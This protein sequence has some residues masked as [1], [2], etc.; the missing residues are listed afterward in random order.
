MSAM[1][2]Q[3]SGV[4]IVCW[5]VCSG[6]D[7][8][9]HQSSVSLTFVRKINRWPVDSPQK[10]SVKRKMF[11]F[12][13]NY[14]WYSISVTSIVNAISCYIGLR[15]NGTWPYHHINVWTFNHCIALTH[16]TIVYAVCAVIFCV[17]FNVRRTISQ[18]RQIL[19]SCV[20]LLHSVINM[21][22]LLANVKHKSSFT[23]VY[24]TIDIWR[25]HIDLSKYR[26]NSIICHK[27]RIHLTSFHGGAL[28]ST[29]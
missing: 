8:R 3:I 29:K 28:K 27:L 17:C 20:P 7:Q 13:S 23:I 14:D 25:W 16:E 18:K 1:A 6:A 5:N 26:H 22:L 24:I 9:K 10:G 15:Y 2:S 21:K 19:R 11:A 4:S 12:D